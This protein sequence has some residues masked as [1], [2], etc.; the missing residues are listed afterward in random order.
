MNGSDRSTVY[1]YET[2]AR[3]RRMVMTLRGDA[4]TAAQSGQIGG[5]LGISMTSGQQAVYADATANQ[6]YQI[7][8]VLAP[9]ADNT[10]NDT[11]GAPTTPDGSRAGSTQIQQD[12]TTAEW[13]N[14]MMRP[15]DSN[16]YVYGGPLPF[17]PV[18]GRYL[19]I[20]GVVF[21]T[22]KISLAAYAMV[23]GHPY[24]GSRAIAAA[25]G[26]LMLMAS[27]TIYKIVIMNTTHS[28]STTVTNQSFQSTGQV[29]PTSGPDTP[30]VPA[31]PTG[32]Q[33]RQPMPVQPLYAH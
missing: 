11:T 5:I 30:V 23:M 15:G 33:A 1:V 10:G 31:A 14:S 32:Y 25:S 12:P 6:L 21:A 20:L 3:G 26:L 16:R 22:V 13:Q 29:T 27:Y 17:V 18:F 7:N 24:A 28:N 2:T 9:S 8:Q 19:I 4:M